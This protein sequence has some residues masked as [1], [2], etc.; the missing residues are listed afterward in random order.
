MNL[1]HGSIVAVQK[2]K[3][4]IPADSHTTDFGHGFYTTT[5]YEQAKKWVEI[6]KFRGQIPKSPAG[7]GFISVF[8]A[9]DDLLQNKNL[10]RLIFESPDREW[11]DFVMNNRT[12]QDF[13]H[14]YDI[15]F[16]PVANDRVYA[17]LTLFESR[18]LDADETIRRLK[19][20]VLVNQIA[21]HTEKSLRELVFVRSNSVL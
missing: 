2:P 12:R 7:N 11:L 4:I 1:Y 9:P 14:E 5:D 18:F 20:Y 8:E 3:I 13:I 17:A 19:T 15:V 6:R 21:F 16:G 10:N